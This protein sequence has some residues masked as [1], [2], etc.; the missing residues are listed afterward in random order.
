MYIL[1]GMYKM[2]E[3]GYAEVCGFEVGLRKSD[4]LKMERGVTFEDLVAAIREGHALDTIDNPSSKRTLQVL[5]IVNFQN[6]IWC[7][8]SVEENGGFFMKTAY[9]SRKYRKI[10]GE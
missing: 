3:V 10:Y 5:L 2:G 7:I 1:K 4:L 9:P 6:E 8:P